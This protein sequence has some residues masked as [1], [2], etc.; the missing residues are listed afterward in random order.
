[1]TEQTQPET[2]PAPTE[3]QVQPQAQVQV[4]QTPS[5]PLAD[6]GFIESL[7]KEYAEAGDLKPE[8]YAR[9][10][11]AGIPK[12]LIQDYASSKV[13]AQQYQE[14][15]AKSQAEKLINACGGKEAVDE[16][17]TWAQKNLDQ[18]SIDAI[19]K[20][21]G[22]P[23]YEARVTALK[24]LQS[25]AGVGGSTLAGK[26]GGTTAHVAYENERQMLDDM[27]NPK[28]HGDP[29][30]R[31]QVD[32]RMKAAIDAGKIKLDNIYHGTR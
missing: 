10:E 28:Y 2:Q 26:S 15:Q 23:S 27:K 8:T 25:R 29:S 5:N 20:Q 7:F 30:F 17:L 19:N 18:A 22:D 9:L 1:M 6:K 4:P 11:S 31:A 24:G 16:A 21:L 13:A 12:D 3:S 32:A 14:F